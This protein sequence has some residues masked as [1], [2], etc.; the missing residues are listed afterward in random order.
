MPQLKHYLVQHGLCTVQMP[1]LIDT[2]G[3]FIKLINKYLNQFSKC[4]FGYVDQDDTDND[5]NDHHRHRNSVLDQEINSQHNHQNKDQDNDICNDNEQLLQKSSTIQN[6]YL[7][8]NGNNLG[9]F[10]EHCHGHKNSSLIENCDNIRPMANVNDDD[11][12]DEEKNYI[13]DDDDDEDTN[14][15]QQQPLLNKDLINK[16]MVIL[17]DNEQH[18]HNGTIFSL[19]PTIICFCND[20]HDQQQQQKN[21]TK[22]NFHCALNSPTSSCTGPLT[23]NTMCSTI[24]KTLTTLPPDSSSMIQLSS[25]HH[26]QCCCCCRMVNNNDNNNN[27]NNRNDNKNCDGND[28]NP[29]TSL[30]N[31]ETE[32]NGMQ[33]NY[34]YSHQLSASLTGKEMP[35]TTAITSLFNSYD[36]NALNN[37]SSNL[38]FAKHYAIADIDNENGHVTNTTKTTMDTIFGSIHSFH[39]GDKVFQCP[40]KQ[41]QL[42]TQH[43]DFCNIEYLSKSICTLD[44][45]KQHNNNNNSINNTNNYH[46]LLHHH[47]G[48]ANEKCL[49]NSCLINQDINGKSQ[50]N[51]KISYNHNNENKNND[52]DENSSTAQTQLIDNKKQL[53]S[54]V[55]R[56]NCHENGHDLNGTGDNGHEVYDGKNNHSSN[57]SSSV[58]TRSTMQLS[59]NKMDFSDL[60]PTLMDHHLANEVVVDDDEDEDDDLIIIEIEDDDEDEDE[61]DDEDDDDCDD[62]C[63]YDDTDDILESDYGYCQ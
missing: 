54:D 26:D 45:N 49:C 2:N 47:A 30:M 41:E 10:N 27:N 39:V 12:Y 60:I 44:N 52:N 36:S 58:S 13:D 9:I 63:E 5:N 43:E 4:L 61:D 37:S 55:K 29:A 22:F 7:T 20:N 8:E 57:E 14:K 21:C 19:Q 28:L 46:Q 34:F 31:Q 59:Y 18:N 1:T 24:N 51:N 56:E 38:N 48:S 11:D 6:D 40:A 17:P 62:C 53:N 42:T 16:N 3:E 32:S 15:I 50:I 33:R 23:T 25:A 35:S